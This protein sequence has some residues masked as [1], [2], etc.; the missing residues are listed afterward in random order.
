ME[1]RHHTPH[2][3]V[4]HYTAQAEGGE[5]SVGGANTKQVECSKPSCVAQGTLQL[6]VEVVF[7]YFF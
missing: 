3:V 4:A 6:D 7:F 5:G 1:G 2:R